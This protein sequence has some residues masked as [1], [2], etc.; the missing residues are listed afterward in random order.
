MNAAENRLRI[1]IEGAKPTRPGGDSPGNKTHC[2]KG[3]PFNEA[4]TAITRD[5][6]RRC[7]QCDAERGRRRRR[8]GKG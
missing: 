7:R 5:G 2:P 6:A 3:H 8:G 1:A 4:N